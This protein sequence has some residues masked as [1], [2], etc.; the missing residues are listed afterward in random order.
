MKSINTSCDDDIIYEGLYYLEPAELIITINVNEENISFDLKR[1]INS[2]NRIAEQISSNNLN[3]IFKRLN[4]GSELTPAGSRYIYKTS[5]T[6]TL[7]TCYLGEVTARQNKY[8]ICI[9]FDEIQPTV[10][11]AQL[12][13]IFASM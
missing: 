3:T 9:A 8:I 7:S 5:N 13:K 4:L 12:L 6:E 10:Y 1:I 11:S 2:Q